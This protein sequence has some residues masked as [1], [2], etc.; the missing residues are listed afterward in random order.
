MSEVFN[1]GFMS[2]KFSWKIFA[3][4]ESGFWKSLRHQETLK[5]LQEEYMSG[6]FKPPFF[7]GF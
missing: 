1:E 5:E 2:F 6:Q 3:Q 7:Q 4:L